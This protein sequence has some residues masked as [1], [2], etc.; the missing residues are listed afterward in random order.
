MNLINLPTFIL[1]FSKARCTLAHIFNRVFG[2]SVIITKN[3]AMPS[4]IN[5]SQNKVCSR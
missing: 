5:F 2:M 1:F 3:G 4:W